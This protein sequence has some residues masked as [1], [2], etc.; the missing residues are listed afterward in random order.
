MLICPNGH[1]PREGRY[2]PDCGGELGAALPAGVSL[3][4]RSPEVYASVNPTF[5][6]PGATGGIPE[7]RAN[8][9]GFRCASS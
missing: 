1:G 9:C 8:D 7:Y 2:C 3:R 4:I 6:L 5:I